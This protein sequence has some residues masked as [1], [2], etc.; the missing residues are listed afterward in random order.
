MDFYILTSYFHF[1]SSNL[2]EEKVLA[3]FGLSLF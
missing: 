3:A 1:K 2:F